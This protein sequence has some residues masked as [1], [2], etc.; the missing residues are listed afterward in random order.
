MLSQ[1]DLAGR[2]VA[3]LLDHS[4]LVKLILKALSLEQN[5]ETVFL[6]MF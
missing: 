2:A 3:E 4:V 1:V 5:L 6:I